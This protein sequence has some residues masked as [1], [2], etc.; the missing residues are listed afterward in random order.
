MDWKSERED[1]NNIKERLSWS[2]TGQELQIKQGGVVACPA[3][4]SM[5][6]QTQ[7]A[8]ISIWTVVS[9]VIILHRH[10]DDLPHLQT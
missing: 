9:S 10:T 8:A 1:R 3:M 4:N 5:T 2:S 7:S 6:E